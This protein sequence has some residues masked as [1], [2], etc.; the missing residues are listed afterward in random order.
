M[1]A[2]ASQ[3]DDATVASLADYFSQEKPTAGAAGDAINVALAV[4]HTFAAQ[5]CHK[6]R[7]PLLPKT[8]PWLSL[9][10]HRSRVPSR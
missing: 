4:S 1:W 8:R 5:L 9:I 10:E 6:S 2:I 7:L 3:L